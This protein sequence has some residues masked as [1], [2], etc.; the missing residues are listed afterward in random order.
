MHSSWFL[1]HYLTRYVKY[2]QT[3][4]SDTYKTFVSKDGKW[5]T[6]YLIIGYEYNRPYV[7]INTLKGDL[8]ITKSY[9]DINLT[10]IAAK[11]YNT[12]LLSQI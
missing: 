1:K 7:D 4:V 10:A 11:V 5:K 3:H 6:N 9:G 2:S 8:G 12:L